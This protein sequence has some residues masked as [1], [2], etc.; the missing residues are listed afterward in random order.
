MAIIGGDYGQTWILTDETT[1]SHIPTDEEKAQFKQ[2]TKE[3][4]RIVR[5]IDRI[6]A[7]RRKSPR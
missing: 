3:H 7:E 4:E 1:L 6:K 5:E 2:A